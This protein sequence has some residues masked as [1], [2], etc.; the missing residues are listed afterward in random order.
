[1][2]ENKVNYNFGIAYQINTPYY[3]SILQNEAILGGL[4]RARET[5]N[6]SFCSTFYFLELYHP[7]IKRVGG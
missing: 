6:V 3:I 5:K 7:T 1:M 2:I 4:K